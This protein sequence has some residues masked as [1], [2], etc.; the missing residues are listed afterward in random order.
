VS[1]RT[2]LGYD[3]HRFVEGRPLILGGVRIE[4]D[5]GLLGHS[6]ADVLTH[7][8]IDALLGAAA[9]GDIGEHFPDTDEQYRDADSLA[10]LR[11]AVA[12]LTDAGFE[13][14]NVD[15]TV[16]IER[17]KL[18]GCRDAMRASLAGALATEIDRVSVKATR[19][20]GM[21]F[22]GREEGVA[23]LAVATLRYAEDT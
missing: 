16:V 9:L 8:I 2:G 21:G 13:I 18:A 20:E 4:H 19:G 11:A 15:A 14:V 22:V 23:A 1:I 3:C 17:P 6:D 5:L 7:A 12:K 10:L